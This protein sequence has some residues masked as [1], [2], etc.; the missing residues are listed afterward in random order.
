MA[1]N[2]E[3]DPSNSAPKLN[4]DDLSNPNQESEPDIEKSFNESLI[5]DRRR[6]Q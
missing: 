4:C 1:S 5:V 2:L 6:E 3:C